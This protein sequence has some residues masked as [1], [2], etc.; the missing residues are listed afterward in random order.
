MHMLARS[1]Y[2]RYRYFSFKVLRPL[3]ARRLSVIIMSSDILSLYLGASEDVE[4]AAIKTIHKQLDDNADGNV[5]LRE[6]AEVS[7]VCGYTSKEEFPL[8]FAFLV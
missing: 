1:L 4:Y 6:S 7:L 5:D 2:I 8:K 3:V